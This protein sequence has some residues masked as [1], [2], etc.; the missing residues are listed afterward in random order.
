MDD[1]QV[2]KENSVDEHGSNNPVLQGCLKINT[3]KTRINIG[4]RRLNLS[5]IIKSLERISRTAIAMKS[6]SRKGGAFSHLRPKEPSVQIPGKPRGSSGPAIPHTAGTHFYEYLPEARKGP[7]SRP[8]PQR[9]PEGGWGPS[10]ARGGRRRLTAPTGMA[11][12]AEKGPNGG[13]SPALPTAPRR[14]RGRAPLSAASAALG[15]IFPRSHIVP[16]SAGTPDRHRHSTPP[17]RLRHSG[18]C[19]LTNCPRGPGPSRRGAGGRRGKEGKEPVGTKL[20][21]LGSAGGVGVAALSC[22]LAAARTVLELRRPLPPAGAAGKR[23]CTQFLAA[24]RF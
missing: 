17:S 10:P 14:L 16:C 13:S 2:C 7:S 23:V 1:K 24:V 15:F 4:A 20:G 12:P 18:C 6:L 3:L 22:L 5:G 21:C 11:A 9:Q 8:R 19:A